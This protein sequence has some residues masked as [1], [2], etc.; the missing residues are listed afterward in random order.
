MVCDIYKD[1]IKEGVDIFI[2]K[3]FLWKFSIKNLHKRLLD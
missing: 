1:F 2:I 3:F